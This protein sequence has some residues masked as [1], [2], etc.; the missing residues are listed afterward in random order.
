MGVKEQIRA[1]KDDEEELTV[2]RS[3]IADILNGHFESVFIKESRGSL[4]EFE[5]RTN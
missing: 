5:N 4:P 3:E 1:L 2:D